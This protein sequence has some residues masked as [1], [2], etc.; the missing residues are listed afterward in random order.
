MLL[1]IKEINLKVTD[2]NK[3]GAEIYFKEEE[4]TRSLED[5]YVPILTLCK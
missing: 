3:N 2:A 1:S 5:R 4:L